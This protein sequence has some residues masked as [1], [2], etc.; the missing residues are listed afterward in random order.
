M[1]VLLV[2]VALSQS[3]PRIFFPELTPGSVLKA[4]SRRWRRLQVW[5]GKKKKRSFECTFDTGFA[6]LPFLGWPHK[7]AYRGLRHTNFLFEHSNIKHSEMPKAKVKKKISLS[8][9]LSL[10]RYNPWNPSDDPLFKPTLHL[11]N[12]GPPTLDETI[13]HPG[14]SFQPLPETFNSWSWTP[15]LKAP[16]VPPH[17]QT[18]PHLLQRKKKK[19]TVLVRVRLM[20]KIKLVIYQQL[21]CNKTFGH[22]WP[23][24]P[25]HCC[26]VV[27]LG[28]GRSTSVRK[29]WCISGEC[30]L[31]SLLLF[32]TFLEFCF[33][34]TFPQNSYFTLL[35][36]SQK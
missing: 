1:A 15:N 23:Q 33:F 11:P 25:I 19:K 31:P 26:A 14:L 2:P 32:P 9:S 20:Q 8:L 6:G 24:R 12:P 22:I 36:G 18:H 13:P 34:P 4:A 3:P 29:G 35:F 7:T 28:E 16:V 5:H 30:R 27:A 10:S 17:P 21:R